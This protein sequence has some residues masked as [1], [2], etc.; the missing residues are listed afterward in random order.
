MLK[1]E[2]ILLLE[3]MKVIQR[4]CF[5][6]NKMS[7]EEYG[8]AMSQYETKLSMTIEDKIET[9]TKIA[10]ILKVKGKK[11]ALEEEKKRLLE[12]IKKV[13]DEYLNKGKLETRIYENMIK[14]YTSRLSEIQEKIAFADAQDA[15]G[16]HKFFNTLITNITARFNK[17]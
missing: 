5:E 12:L 1:E 11:I 10:N 13:Q 8:Q 15:L 9:E 14:S 2:E 17:K 6:N 4:E 3:L 16:K 7:M